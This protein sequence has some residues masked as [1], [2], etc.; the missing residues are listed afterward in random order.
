M[1]NQGWPRCPK[2]FITLNSQWSIH[3]VDAIIMLINLK[4]HS[5]RLGS[6]GTGCGPAGQVHAL[7]HAEEE[8]RLSSTVFPWP[9]LIGLLREVVD[10]CRPQERL[11]KSASVKEPSIYEGS[12]PPRRKQPGNAVRLFHRASSFLPGKDHFPGRGEQSETS[13]QGRTAMSNENGT[14]Y[15]AFCVPQLD[16]L[17]FVSHSFPKQSSCPALYLHYV[18]FSCLAFL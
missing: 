17:H 2:T 5:P 10:L 9:V 11:C 15:S 4:F 6:G 13:A 1:H 16:L 12:P 7:T 8:S 14:A 18:N 3:Q